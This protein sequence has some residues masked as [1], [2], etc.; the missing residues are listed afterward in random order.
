M[1]LLNKSEKFKLKSCPWTIDLLTKF[2]ASLSYFYPFY[3][4]IYILFFNER[5]GENYLGQCHLC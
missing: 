4:Y 3:I 5:H 2:E 1:Y